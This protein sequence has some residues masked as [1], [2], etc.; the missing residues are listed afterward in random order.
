MDLKK[1]MDS[2]KG[3]LNPMLVKVRCVKPYHPLKSL[4]SSP[5]LE[6]Y[7]PDS[8]RDCLLPSTQD[9]ASRH[10]ATEPTDRLQ[11]CY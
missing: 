1:Y 6:L 7:V 4:F 5:P 2:V 3:S 9:T 10:E 11:W 8:A